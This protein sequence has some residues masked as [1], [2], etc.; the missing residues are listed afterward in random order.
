MAKQHLL[1]VALILSGSV[2]FAACSDVSVTDGG[3]GAAGEAGAK[4]E[5]GGPT[6]EAGTKGDAGDTSEGG[7]GGDVGDVDPP[8]LNPVGV[9]VPAAGPAT[10]THLLV[11]AS[12][13][14]A[15]T[16]EVASVTLGTGKVLGFDTY[17]DG[18]VVAVGS[19]GVSFAIERSNDKVNLLDAGKVSTTFDLKDKGTDT[20]PVDSKAYVP[21]LNKSAIAILDLTEGKVSRRIDLSEYQDKAD[22]DGS[23]EVAEGVYEPKANI[24]YFLLQRIDISTI[25]MDGLPCS[26]STALIVGID[27]ATDKQVDLNGAAKGNAIELKLVNPRSLSVNADGDTLYLLAE[28][29]HTGTKKKLRGVEVVDLTTAETTVSYSD[30]TTEYLNSMILIGGSAALIET[31]DAMFATHWRKL[32]IAS[33]TL[34]GELAKVPSAPSFDGK[35]LLGVEVTGTVGSVVRYKLATETSTVVAATSWAGDYSF[36]S[37]TALVQ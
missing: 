16:S 31:Y 11:A 9:I 27:A 10:S 25:G 34:A 23:V 26:T 15:G 32:D 36:P 18:D 33:G 14:M 13:F 21:L 3:G 29:C 19:A 7:A 24:V 1:A 17:K 5:A 35:D 8:V 28:G 37:S 6:G 22:T 12:D 2:M 4:G 20:A 30:T